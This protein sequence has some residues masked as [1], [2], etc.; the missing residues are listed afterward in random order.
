VT[1]PD[2]AWSGVA[3]ALER[4]A[5]FGHPADGVAALGPAEP[6]APAP[7]RVR[8]LAGVCLGA[9]G[10]YRDAARWLAPGGE[11][12]GSP[13]ASCLASHLRQVGRH[14]EAERLDQLALATATDAEARADALVG[15][16]ADAVGRHDVALARERLALAR[17]RLGAPRSG[18]GSGEMLAV[19]TGDTAWRI[20]VRLSWV[21]A[22]TA[23]LAGEAEIAV[24]HGRI[25]RQTSRS[26]AACRHAVKSELVLGVALDAA[27]RTRRA[28][29]VLRAAA[30][31]AA[32]LGLTPLQLPI[33]QV[34]AGALQAHAPATAERERLCA[35]AAQRISEYPSGRGRDG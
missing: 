9:L 26:A 32:R 25:A 28:V 10:R 34:L 4:A 22:E 11:P 14:A 17:D 20:G 35:R 12:A 6:D 5:W 23:L 16:V 8:W 19:T 15:L 31:G 18:S 21:T 13:A 1:G 27:G 33:H 30:G 29:R 3:R 2:T 7:E 24:E